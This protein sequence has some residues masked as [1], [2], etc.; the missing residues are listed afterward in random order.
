MRS[1]LMLAILLF[2]GQCMNAEHILQKFQLWGTGSHLDN[3]NLY[4]GW[5]N[6]F[7]QARGERGLELANCLDS[8]TYDQTIAMIDKHYKDHPEHW[9]RGVGIEILEVMTASGSPCEGKSP[10]VN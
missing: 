3:L 4:L 10:L 8:L 6:G 5:T 7:F 9:S 1:R 2:S